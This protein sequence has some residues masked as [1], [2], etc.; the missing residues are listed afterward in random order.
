MKKIFIYS[1]LLIA[2]IAGV[3]SHRT[4]LAAETL[5]RLAPKESADILNGL[6]QRVID[7]EKGYKDAAEQV[8]SKSLANQ[9]L[10]KS[11]DR[12]SFVS[13]LQSEV[14]E[15][16]FEPEQNGTVEGAA[17]RIWMDFKTGA[18][19]NDNKAVLEAVKSAESSTLEDYRN[20]I[21]KKLPQE[22][23]DILKNQME[24]IQD[25]YNWAANELNKQN[26]NL[27]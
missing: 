5:P 3:N 22:L 11:K 2:G 26:E 9:L 21:H 13:Q 18:S 23:E 12:R 6:I 4:V 1:M 16:G 17:T 8:D 24:K 7:G 10:I 25:S 20:A 15:L 19:K 27:N 14:R